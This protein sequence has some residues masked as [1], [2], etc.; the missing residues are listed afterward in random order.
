MHTAWILPATLRATPTKSKDSFNKNW[1]TSGLPPYVK[2]TSDPPLKSKIFESFCT[3]EM[4]LSCKG[5]F[6][7]Y[8]LKGIVVIQVFGKSWLNEMMFKDQRFKHHTIY[9]F[10]AFKL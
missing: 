8:K 3:Q 1:H 10:N 9:S 4:I 5:L 7:K 6:R 2:P